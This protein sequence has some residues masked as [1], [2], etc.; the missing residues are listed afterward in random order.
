MRLCASASAERSALEMFCKRYEQIEF[1][2]APTRCVARVFPH[3]AFYAFNAIVLALWSVVLAFGMG[4]TLE[5]CLPE[6]PQA[7]ADYR[8]A[9]TILQ[10]S[11]ELSSDRSEAGSFYM[12]LQHDSATQGER[13]EDYVLDAKTEIKESRW[14]LTNGVLRLATLETIACARHAMQKMQQLDNG[15]EYPPTSF[16]SSALV[17]GAPVLPADAQNGAVSFLMRQPCPEAKS[18]ECAGVWLS[19]RMNHA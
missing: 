6:T 2:R 1:E 15:L 17:L 4:A 5:H 13:D 14:F 18:I 11:C 7:A 16:L 9:Q 10:M 8:C 19:Q 3:G 12:W